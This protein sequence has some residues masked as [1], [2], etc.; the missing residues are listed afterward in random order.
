MSV[1]RICDHETCSEDAS[2]II[3]VTIRERTDFVIDACSEECATS[4]FAPKLTEAMVE[5]EAREAERA[6]ALLRASQGSSSHEHDN[7]T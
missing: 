4:L 1:T 5:S 6:A 3:S 2:I 7:I